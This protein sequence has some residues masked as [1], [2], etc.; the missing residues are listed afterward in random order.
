LVVT[1]FD[2]KRL[3]TGK[4]KT[5]GQ[6]LWSCQCSFLQVSYSLT[7]TTTCARTNDYVFIASQIDSLRDRKEGRD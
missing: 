1:S 2:K 4:G 3:M 6:R 5:G 7:Y